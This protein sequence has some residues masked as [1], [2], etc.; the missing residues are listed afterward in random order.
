MKAGRH[1]HRSAILESRH[2]MTSFAVLLPVPPNPQK[3][4]VR[5]LPWCTLVHDA[6][7]YTAVPIPSSNA[8]D[9]LY[10]QS[11]LTFSLR[12]LD[13]NERSSSS[14]G[15]VVGHESGRPCG[16]STIEGCGNA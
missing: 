12:M 5:A 2:T 13:E 7:S 8:R 3:R 9:S 14:V 4:Q 15:L 16:N 6:R 10:H 11:F 1:S